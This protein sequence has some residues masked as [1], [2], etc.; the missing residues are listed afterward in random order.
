M[1]VKVNL[2]SLQLMSFPPDTGNPLAPGAGGSVVFTNPTSVAPPPTGTDPNAVN[3]TTAPVQLGAG[4]TNDTFTT[5]PAGQGET[6]QIV[7]AGQGTQINL[8]TGSAEVNIIGS[9]MI[10]ESV[11]L[12]GG[13]GSKTFDA[14]NAA[15]GTT[16]INTAVNVTGNT[17]QQTVTIA[18]AASGLAPAGTGT[19]TG[20]YIHGGTGADTIIGSNFNDFLRGGA[21]ND[22]INALAG[23]DLVRGGAGSDTIFLGTGIDTLLY[24]IDQVGFGNDT[25]LDFAPGQDVIAVAPGQG[26]TAVVNGT[27]VTFT[28]AAGTTTLTSANGSVFSQVTFLT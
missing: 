26:I 14:Q 9:S 25:L 20:A 4:A 18:Q 22:W 5:T 15:L 3:A 21:G 19:F 28:S 10:I 1:C 6:A 17:P 11:Q 16:P 8:G 13:D 2:S 27:E 24:T 12:V 7:G 23:N